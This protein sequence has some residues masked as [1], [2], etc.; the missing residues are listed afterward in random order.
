MYLSIVPSYT[1]TLSIP[2]H[3]FDCMPAGLTVPS[4]KECHSL[5]CCF[6]HN[7]NDLYSPTCFHSIPAEYGYLASNVTTISGVFSTAAIPGKG[8]RGGVRKVYRLSE[9]GEIALEL[10]PLR[11]QTNL[12][13]EAWSLVAKVQYGGN[14]DV[15]RVLIYSPEHDD[16]QDD[17]IATNTS[18]HQLEVTVTQDPGGDFNVTVKRLATEEDIM[19]TVFGPMI[20][21]EGFAE[22]T[23]RLPT[24]HLYGL[25][26]R[27]NFAFT[28]NW[29]ERSRWPLFT[30]EKST[31][32]GN[33]SV[34]TGSS[35]A[36]P[37]FM[38][39]EKTPGYMFGLYLKTSAPVEVGVNPVPAVVFRGVGSLWDIRIM[40]GPTPRDVSRQYTQMVGRPAMPPYWALGYH[41]CRAAPQEGNFST[42]EYVGSY[43]HVII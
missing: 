26:L 5:G 33:V 22:L 25:G 4:E 27:R 42:Y 17:F 40:A 16:F 8:S 29:N 37:F 35:G 9:A 2:S 31:V 39:F 7:S 34:A 28:P 1:L 11:D 20:Y 14:G 3:R 41:L 19:E 13:N 43:L 15:V 24:S 21:G 38:N 10:S 18:T 23:T 30:E 6:D 36:H 12:G 32:N